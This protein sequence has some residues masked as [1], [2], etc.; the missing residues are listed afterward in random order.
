FCIGFVLINLLENINYLDTNISIVRHIKQA[1]AYISNFK[2]TQ[3]GNCVI[4]F[5]T[6][7][8]IT[9]FD[10]SKYKKIA[11]IIIGANLISA[12][13]LVVFSALTKT[14]YAFYFFS[15]YYGIFVYFTTI[16]ILIVFRYSKFAQKENSRINY[17]ANHSFIIYLLHVLLIDIVFYFFGTFIYNICSTAMCFLYIP[18]LIFLVYISTLA[19]SLLFSL[20]PKKIRKY[21]C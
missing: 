11:Y 9:T 13:L 2:I 15:D 5:I 20:I 17:L 14:T 6:G 16:A 7:W 12:V 8:Y 4:L 21:L 1:V 3:L 19:V 18:A 10:M